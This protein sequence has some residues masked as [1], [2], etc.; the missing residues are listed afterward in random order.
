MLIICL[1][2][3]H[4][5]KKGSVFCQ[6]QAIMT[7]TNDKFSETVYIRISSTIQPHTAQIQQ[8]KPPAASV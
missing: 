6:R 4:H 8:G 5:K 1:Q 3:N 2:D 7:Q